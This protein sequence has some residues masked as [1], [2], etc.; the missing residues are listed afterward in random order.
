M[1]KLRNKWNNFH[2]NFS[3]SLFFYIFVQNDV[4]IY[5]QKFF[6]GYFEIEYN[7]GSHA[8]YE[9][10]IQKYIGILLYSGART[11]QCKFHLNTHQ[12]SVRE[13]MA[14]MMSSYEKSSLW[15]SQRVKSI[16]RLYVNQAYTYFRVFCI[17][18]ASLILT[19]EFGVRLIIAIYISLTRYYTLNS[20]VQER[21]KSTFIK[22]EFFCSSIV[23]V[24]RVRENDRLH[25]FF[26]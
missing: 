12:H 2:L 20:A 19:S 5:I 17:S 9:L 18:R 3:I 23:C 7:R 26:Q 1:K 6:H 4:Q 24:H 10:N 13:K 22:N 21:D 25:L 16:I 11:S 14:K 8:L 15:K